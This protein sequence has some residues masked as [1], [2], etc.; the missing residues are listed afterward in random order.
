M[1]RISEK[2]PFVHCTF[3]EERGGDPLAHTNV[4]EG[5]AFCANC[6]DTDHDIVQVSA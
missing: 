3:A 2:G 1:I 4:W 6:G 5:V